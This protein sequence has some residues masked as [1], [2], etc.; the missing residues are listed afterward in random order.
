M[1]LTLIIS[2]CSQSLHPPIF[3]LNF[4]FAYFLSLHTHTQNH[5]QQKLLDGFMCSFFSEVGYMLTIILIEESV[6]TINLN[7]ISRFH[8]VHNTPTFSAQDPLHLFHFTTEQRQQCV[9]G[10]FREDSCHMFHYIA[11]PLKSFS[12]HTHV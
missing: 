7:P 2:L 10:Y 3:N 5:T 12:T 9:A 11:L 8:P 4:S 1:S 6:H